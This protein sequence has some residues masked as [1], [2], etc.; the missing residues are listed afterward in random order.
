MKRG[1]VL[2]FLLLLVLNLVWAAKVDQEV[3]TKLSQEGQ[4][5]VIVILKDGSSKGMGIASTENSVLSKLK[6]KNKKMGI[7]SSEEYDLELKHQY[8]IINGFS[9][10]LTAV[11]LEKLRNDH[12]VE[13]IY[14]NQIK[15]IFLADS[16]PI[17]QAPQVWNISVN[18]INI[19][20]S[21]QTVCILDTGVNYNHTALGGGWGNKVIGGYDY[22][23]NDGNPMDDHG[24]GSHVAGIIA[25]TNGTYKGVAPEAKIVAMKVCDAAG[26]CPDSDILAAMQDCINNA[27]LYNISVISISLGGDQYDYYCDNDINSEY[28]TLI[29]LATSRNISV[30]I[31]T[32]NTDIYYPNATA[33]ISAPACVYNATRVTAV[34]KSDIMASYAFRHSNFS[35]ILA[36]P[37][38]SII[39]INRSGGFISNS[40]TSMATPHV[41]GAA[42]LLQQYYH[43]THNSPLTPSQTKQI[44]NS[45]GEEI[46]DSSG[47]GL[48]FSRINVYAAVNSIDNTNITFFTPQNN[49]YHNGYLNLNITLTDQNSIYFS[50]YS[51]TNSSGSILQSNQNNSINQNTFRWT[52]FV[53]LSNSTFNHGNYILSITANDSFG[54]MATSSINFVLDKTNPSLIIT[55][56][57]TEPVYNDATITFKINASDANLNL[58]GVYF[59]SN[60]SSNWTNY[61]MHNENNVTFNFTLTGSEN[62]TNQKNIAYLFHVYDLAGNYNTSEILNFTV[63][64]RNVSSA[65]IT[66]PN[67][68]TLEVG[69]SVFF[70]AGYVHLDNDTITFNWTLNG[71]QISDSSSFNYSIN[72]TGTY[73][74]VVNISDGLSSSS[75]NL[76]LEVN[77]TSAPILDSISYLNQV[78]L[79]RDGNETIRVLIQDYSGISNCTLYYNNSL[80]NATCNTTSNSWNCTWILNNL[81]LGNNYSFTLNFTDNSSNLHSNSSTYY[82]NVTSCSDGILN[83]NEAGVDCGGSCSTSCSSSSSS[84]SSGGGGG[85]GGGGTTTSTY[86]LSE[87]Q[88]QRGYSNELGKGDRIKIKFSNEDH[89][90]ALNQVTSVSAQI[91][92][93][94]TLQQATLLVGEEKKFELN[95]DKYYDLKIKLN[96]ISEKLKVNLS[97]SSLR[98]LMA[99]VTKNNLNKTD[100]T[101]NL[102]QPLANQT[103]NISESQKISEK[104]SLNLPSYLPFLAIAILLAILLGIYSYFKYKS[105]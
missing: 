101:T 7:L 42:I 97:V 80:I 50:N 58:S 86:I 46:N 26:S 88:F 10:T 78:H 73:F 71:T 52:D 100:Q 21:G 16:I 1:V 11:G 8:S 13:S 75:S 9:G 57:Q 103:E 45:T 96:S 2:V 20:G 18:G 23:N 37:G 19:N 89:Y 6:I 49:S 39:S 95:G 3:T 102:S 24:H 81:L 59:E 14:L 41:S 5:S 84:S 65:N 22:Y 76:T 105:R 38:S 74:L 92:V 63:Q 77:D 99:P 27:S 31:A 70:N 36:A 93:T 48:F 51:L 12:F 47:S 94:S 67:S 17:I 82:F 34:D 54:N 98:E 15:H 28:A 35:D 62:L 56:N 53:N 55:Q 40:G 61:S 4:V 90:V 33:G 104:P 29:N 72:Q 66:S 30:V 32:G 68:S 60:F 85:G 91:N 83:G 43:L 79:Q 44:L 87:E 64:N 25:S 69:Q